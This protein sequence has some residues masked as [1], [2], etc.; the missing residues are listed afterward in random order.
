MPNITQNK[1]TFNNEEDFETIRKY[2]DRITPEEGV[3]AV[4]G[5][6]DDKIFLANLAEKKRHIVY[7]KDVVIDHDINEYTPLIN[8]MNEINVGDI[9]QRDR[10]LNA[11]KEHYVKLREDNVFESRFNFNVIEPVEAYDWE[12]DKSRDGYMI[13]PDK[14]IFWYNVNTANWGT[15]WNAFEVVWDED[16]HAVYFQTAWSDVEPIIEK[17]ANKF[18]D[19]EMGYEFL[20]EGDDE[21][22]YLPYNHKRG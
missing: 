17:L 16:E 20:Y 10:V 18:P 13:E 6:H 3:Y 4:T 12:I 7:I 22:A 14:D 11:T 21:V 2:M 1:L 15:K 8:Y 5:F 19:I 9:I